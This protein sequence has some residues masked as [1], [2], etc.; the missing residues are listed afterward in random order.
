MNHLWRDGFFFFTDIFLSSLVVDKMLSL[1]EKAIARNKKEIDNIM[2]AIK[3]DMYN[4][5]MK[6]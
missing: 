4:E 3:N 1:D 2:N 5:V 6:D